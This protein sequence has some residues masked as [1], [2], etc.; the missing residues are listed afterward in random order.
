MHIPTRKRRSHIQHNL[1]PKASLGPKCMNLMMM[2]K[3]ARKAKR[4]IT[5]PSQLNPTM[6]EPPVH[7]TLH[8]RE[9]VVV[10][11]P[12]MKRRSQAQK[13]TMTALFWSRPQK[14][15]RKK[16]TQQH[17]INIEAIAVVVVEAEEEVEDPDEVDPDRLEA[18]EKKVL[19]VK[20]VN[21]DHPEVTGEVAKVKNVETGDLEA[22]IAA[23]KK[24]ADLGEAEETA[25]VKAARK[26]EDPGEVVAEVRVNVPGEAVEKL[27]LDH[28][29]APVR[30]NTIPLNTRRMLP[31]QPGIKYVASI[32]IS[33]K[34]P[35][36]TK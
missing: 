16:L 19:K 22:V 30:K 6:L 10:M 13:L 33:V 14:R 28:N 34:D 35:T 12:D 17:E 24:V 27:V 23:A 26:V 7:S 15:R 11:N 21:S 5:K 2:R 18:T 4:S 9:V 3:K 20:K 36:M 1:A 32:A 25:A 8:T 31:A 29:A